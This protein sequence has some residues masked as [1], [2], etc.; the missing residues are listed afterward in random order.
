LSFGLEFQ[1]G[2]VAGGELEAVEEDTGF[3]GF[4]PAGGE[5]GDDGGE[6]G[7][8]GLA[9][10][11]LGEIEG[12]RLGASA[13]EDGLVEIAVASVEGVVE[14]AEL[15]SFEGGGAAA[16]SGSVAVAAEEAG[17]VWVLRV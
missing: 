13:V 10:F 1:D 2:G 7:L 3:P 5:G 4:E 15:G 8:D 6:G 16:V 9:I 17:H 12:A 14:E 11:E